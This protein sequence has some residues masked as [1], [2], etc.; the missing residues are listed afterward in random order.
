MNPG[1]SADNP[2]DLIATATSDQLNRVI[3]YVDKQLDLIDGMIVIF[4]SN[5]M[6]DITGNL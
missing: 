2:I 5:G 3:E 6:I 4:G 1:A